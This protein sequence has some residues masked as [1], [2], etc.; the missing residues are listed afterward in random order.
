MQCLD[1][2]ARA[3]ELKGV[4]TSHADQAQANHKHAGDGAALKGNRQRGIDAAACSLGGTHVGPYVD[5]HAD[6]ACDAGEYRADGKS[7]S[8]V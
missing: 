1:H 8:G 7:D 6:K 3:G 4:K 2:V 5:V